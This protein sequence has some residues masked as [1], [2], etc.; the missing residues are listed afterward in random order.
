MKTIVDTCVWSLA[1]RRQD[2]TKIS[3]GNVKMIAQLQEV[4]REGRAI[5]IGPI[6]Q[7]IL[8]GIREK[9]RFAKTQALLDP[10]RDEEINAEDFVKAARL[11]NVC[12]D[13]GVECGPVDIFI[14]AVA[15]R[16]Q[17]D[18]LTYDQGLKRCIEVLRT[19]GLLHQ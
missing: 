1:L 9:A 2:Q 12:R 14:C 13:N 15:T 6:R 16:L 7:E 19:E 17:C 4:I 10:F 3:A 5:I 8:S 18:I 11:F